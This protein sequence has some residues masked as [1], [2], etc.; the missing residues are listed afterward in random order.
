MPFVCGS[1]AVDGDTLARLDALAHPLAC[2]HQ[3]T[4]TTNNASFWSHLPSLLI[5]LYD[6]FSVACGY[7]KVALLLLCL[8][9]I[10]ESR[11]PTVE[12]QLTSAH[13]EHDHQCFMA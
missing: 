12:T 11:L 3:Q 1:C 10:L 5:Q 4:Y 13:Q 9:V 2:P 8:T 6:G 7:I